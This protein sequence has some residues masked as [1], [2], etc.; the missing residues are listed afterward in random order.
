MA[1]G[2]MPYFL[3]D[4]YVR[5][6]RL[7]DQIN[8]AKPSFTLHAGDIKAS[9]VLCSEEYYAKMVDYFERFKQP[10]IYTPGDNEWTD[11]NRE[12]AGAYDP[13]ERLEVLRKYFFSKSESFGKKPMQL[14]S[15]SENPDYSEYVENKQWSYNGVQFATLHVVGTN[16]NKIVDD[17]ARM[18]EYESRDAANL[19][20][21]DQLFAKAKSQNAEAVVICMQADMFYPDKGNN[22]FDN[23]IEKLK[24]LTLN[25]GKPVLLINGDSHK[26]LVDKPLYHEEDPKIGMSRVIQN[27]TRVQVFGEADMHAV[28]ITYHPGEKDPF[29][30][31]QVFIEGN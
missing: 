1:I 10:L 6:E 3:P 23:T 28:S 25:F 8:S 4:D 20:W 31:H 18:E 22:G 19:W 2:D 14:I 24:T 30:I 5:F 29:E 26:F 13:Q 9:K 7:I 27:F 17:A 21:L 12:L 11:C 15:Q 16:N